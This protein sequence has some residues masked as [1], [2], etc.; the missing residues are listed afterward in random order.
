MQRVLVVDDDCTS[1]LIIKRMLEG[2]GFGCD[3]VCNGQEAVVAATKCKYAAILMDMHMPVLNGCDAA[4][5]ILKI[6]SSDRPLIIGMLS[7]DEQ[8]SR[9]LFIQAGMQVVLCKP[10]HKP[11]LAKSLEIIKQHSLPSSKV[12]VASCSDQKRAENMLS[13]QV[14]CDPSEKLSLTPAKQAQCWVSESV[15]NSITQ[16]T[17]R[18]RKPSMPSMGA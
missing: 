1:H 16:R 18:K 12:D 3:A 15:T 8:S 5:C 14:E 6:V 17:Q 11:V 4:M 10:I 13:P 2:M 9:E 7:F